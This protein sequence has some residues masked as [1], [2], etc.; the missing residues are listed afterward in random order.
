MRVVTECQTS[1]L[2][3]PETKEIKIVVNGEKRLVPG[4]LNVAA[5]L[6][7][8]AIVP[9]RVAVELNGTIVRQ[10]LWSATPVADGAQLEIVQFVGGG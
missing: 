7:A 1:G 8:L 3:Q 10:A 4:G 5:L 2:Q 9:S 6:E